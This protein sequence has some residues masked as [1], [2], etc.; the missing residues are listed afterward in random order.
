MSTIASPRDPSM[1]LSAR[2]LPGTPVLTSPAGSARPSLDL[3]RSGTASPS[4]PPAAP[5]PS[6]AKRK[7]RA[8]LREY[9]NIQRERSGTSSVS[10][11]PQQQQQQQDGPHSEVPAGELDAPDFDVAEYV[12]K[13]AAENGLEDLLHVYTRVLAEIRALDAEKKALVYDNYN[14]LITAT[15]T[16]RKMRTNMDPLNPLAAQLDPRMAHIQ[17][18]AT[19]ICE[20][21]RTA[22][23]EQTPA[24]L[25]AQRARQVASDVLAVPARLRFLA[26]QKRWEDAEKEWE[27]PRKLLVAWKEKGVGGEEV[28][29][30]LEEGDGIVAEA[31]KE[32]EEGEE[33]S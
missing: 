20:S 17:E 29:R 24:L 9:Y 7:N 11:P 2:R 10:P 28:G 16:I 32:A 8:A 33:S 12:R 27:L 23:P 4:L 15:E 6:A 13:A 25:A 21:L 19:A 18:Q 30:L 31:D 5:V 1:G 22:T 26:A 14:K 3:P